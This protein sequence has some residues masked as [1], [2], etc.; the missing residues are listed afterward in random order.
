MLIDLLLCA[1]CFKNTDH[2]TRILVSQMGLP[3]EGRTVGQ[4]SQ[5]AK[6]K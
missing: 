2:Q 1:R 5:K 6:I 4:I 3:G